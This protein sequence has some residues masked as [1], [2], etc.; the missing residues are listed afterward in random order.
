MTEVIAG[1]NAMELREQGKAIQ[2]RRK[3]RPP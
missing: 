2:V 1:L 3:D